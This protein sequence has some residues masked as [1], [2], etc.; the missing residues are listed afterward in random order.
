MPAPHHCSALEQHYT[1]KTTLLV[2]LLLGRIAVL[3]RCGLPLQME[4]TARTVCRDC[5]PCKNGWTN[6][7]IVWDVDSGGPKPQGTMY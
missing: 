3:C 1:Y 2:R 4:G 6:R 7:D 5:E